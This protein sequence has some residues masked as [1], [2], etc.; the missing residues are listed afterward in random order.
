MQLNT[1]A[2]ASVVAC[3]IALLPSIGSARVHADSRSGPPGDRDWTTDRGTP[4]LTRIR[5]GGTP[6]D[7]SQSLTPR[8]L[9]L[10][11]MDMPS[12]G[13]VESPPEYAPAR[14]VLFEYGGGWSSV[15]TACVAELTGDPTHDDIA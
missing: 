8:A 7:S 14:G 10:P 6:Y 1:I 5:E 11:P 13:F 2:R 9:T 3:A 12:N 15:V 4:A